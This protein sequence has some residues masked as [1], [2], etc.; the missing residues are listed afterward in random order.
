MKRFENKSNKK[1]NK[2]TVIAISLFSDVEFGADVCVCVC[3]CVCGALDAPPR[4]LVRF[5]NKTQR[6]KNIKDSPKLIKLI[7]TRTLVAHITIGL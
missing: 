6:M 4:S 3:V 7:K 1:N 5:N 2:T